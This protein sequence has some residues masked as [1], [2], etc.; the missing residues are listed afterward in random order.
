MNPDAHR[1]L[2]AYLLAPDDRK[3]LGSPGRHEGGVWRLPLQLILPKTG[4]HEHVPGLI[5]HERKRREA[6]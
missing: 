5:A 2:I 6:E 1:L 4:A 3:D